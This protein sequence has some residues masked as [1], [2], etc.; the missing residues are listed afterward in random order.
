MKCHLNHFAIRFGE[1]VGMAGRIGSVSKVISFCKFGVRRGARS[2]DL[3]ARCFRRSPG[4]TYL[5]C[6]PVR[7]STGG[8]NCWKKRI[9]RGW[10]A[11]SC[12]SGHFHQSRQQKVTPEREWRLRVSKEVRP[13]N[14]REESPAW[15]AFSENL[16]LNWEQAK[17]DREPGI[18]NFASRGGRFLKSRKTLR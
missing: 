16:S 5:I 12:F 17:G 2:V 9:V 13:G 7:A 8:R 15:G 3:V 11:S 14:R 10:L 6:R 18:N 4:L 1:T